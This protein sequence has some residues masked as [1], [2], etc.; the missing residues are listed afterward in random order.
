VFTFR[1]GKVLSFEIYLDPED[2]LEAV[3]LRE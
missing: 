3:G 1:D 2:A